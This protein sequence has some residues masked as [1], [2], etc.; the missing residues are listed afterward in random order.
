MGIWKNT[1]QYNKN[2][3]MLILQIHCLRWHTQLSFWELI[4]CLHSYAA[5]RIPDRRSCV[6]I[7]FDQIF[8]PRDLS[9]RLYCTCR[10]WLSV[11]MRETFT[12]KSCRNQFPS[13]ELKE[14]TSFHRTENVPYKIMD[15]QI[16][17][18]QHPPEKCLFALCD[19]CTNKINI[20]TTL[21]CEYSLAC[22]NLSD[23]NKLIQSLLTTE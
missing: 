4:S 8:L 3:W 9:T 6:P 7:G 15:P 16:Q 12:G 14:S 23:T 18:W 10:H 21:T 11:H 19:L 2:N 13:C 22:T 20:P 5:C 17:T 1:V